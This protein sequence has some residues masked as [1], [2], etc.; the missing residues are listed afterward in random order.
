M[1]RRAF[2][3]VATAIAAGVV[4]VS[5][6]SC[7]YAPSAD[8]RQAIAPT[9]TLRVG[10]YSGSPTSYVR[11]KDGREVGLALEMGRALGREM[12]V[13][14]QVVEFDRIAL[15]LAAMKK[16]DIDFTFTNASEERR[17]DIDFTPTVVRLELG[18]L[19]PSGSKLANADEVDGSGTRVGVTQGSSSEHVL[20]QRF[21][22]AKLVPAASLPKAAEMLRRGEIDAYAT[23]KGIL[24]E[25]ADQVPGSRILPGRWGV[26]NLAVAY[27]KGRAAG[28]AYLAQFAEQLRASGELK[29]MIARSGLRGAA[30]D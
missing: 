19:V 11:S 16:G 27:P 7:A 21:K 3:L 5:V 9:G 6:A 14:V 12:G 13:P 22:N 26:E 20:S 1:L 28:A 29:D 15:I 2:N 4:A 23:N 18:Y 25:L 17:G 10:V 24:F 30:N 8:V